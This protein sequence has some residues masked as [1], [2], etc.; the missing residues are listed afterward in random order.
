MRYI[1]RPRDKSTVIGISPQLHIQ[2]I[3]TNRAENLKRKAVG[4]EI[5]A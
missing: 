5:E 3:S 4:E 2:L 1:T